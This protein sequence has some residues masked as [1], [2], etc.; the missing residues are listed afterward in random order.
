M[1]LA[2]LNDYRKVLSLQWQLNTDK[3]VFKLLPIDEFTQLL[4]PKKRHILK[5][6]SMFY[7]PLGLLILITVRCKILF[8]EICKRKYAWDTFFLFVVLNKLLTKFLLEIRMLRKLIFRRSM[9][10]CA[11]RKVL[12]HGFV[13][14]CSTSRQ[15]KCLSA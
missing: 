12:L 7:D 15:I 4:T 8:Q 5:T 3:I 10:C 2:E 14:S 13:D 1:E 6:A 11:E 9:L